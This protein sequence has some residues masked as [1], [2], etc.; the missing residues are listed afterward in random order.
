VAQIDDTPVFLA[1]SAT[2]A[3]SREK[4]LLFAAL[5]PLNG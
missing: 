4:V 5:E 2:K 3:G 1:L